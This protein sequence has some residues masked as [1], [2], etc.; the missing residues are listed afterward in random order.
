MQQ[1]A[2]PENRRLP[3]PH[4][5]GILIIVDCVVVGV[6]VADHLLGSPIR[7]IE[8]FVDLNREGN[9]P[10]WYSSVKW[11]LAASLLA[12]TGYV[13]RNHRG[14]SVWVFALLPLLFVLFSLDEI[15]EIHEYL[16]HLSDALLPG[17]TRDGTPFSVTGIW[18]F[19]VG[20][21]F[22]ILFGLLVR[23]LR[24]W[25]VGAPSSLIKIIVGVVVSLAG[26]IGVEGLVTF[27]INDA[28]LLAL[29][30]AVE[31]ALEIAGGT[32][33]VWGCYEYARSCTSFLPRPSA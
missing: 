3:V 17:G 5:I 8:E 6:Y 23:N 31:E 26:A 30:V 12:V 24:H 4:W 15:A 9:L 14:R 11:F 25:F 32:I 20:L 28:Y 13:N 22:L 29:Q 27:V 18:M 33:V 7:Y 21:P 10:T 1:G 2:I 16:G 19:V